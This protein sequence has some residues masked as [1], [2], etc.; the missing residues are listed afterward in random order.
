MITTDITIIGAGLTG[1][2]LQYLLRK[3]DF[4]VVVIEARNR[5]GGRIHTVRSQ[6]NAPVEMGATWIGKKHTSLNSLLQELGIDTFQQRLGKMTP[7]LPSSLLDIMGNTH[8]WMGESIKFALTFRQPFWRAANTSG[9]LVSNVGPIPEM[10]DH[11]NYEDNRFALKGFLNGSYFSVS[12][13]QR[14]EMILNQLKKY[15]GNAV[16]T[17]T[18]YQETVWAKD[19]F[20]YKSYSNHVLPHQH[21]GH[22]VY[23]TPVLEGR[24]FI[25]GSETANAF[26]GY[27]EGAV[28]SAQDVYKQIIQRQ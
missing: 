14:L 25:A 17:Y 5:P 20:S 2:T 19:P 1:L 16:E 4:S 24:L 13:A 22:A 10:Y 26:P 7:A 27:M 23:G 15:Y 21:N 11:S 3:H 12:K 28:R 18:D 6:E 8:T 9:T